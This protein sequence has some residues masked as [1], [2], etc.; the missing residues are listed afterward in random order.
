MQSRQVLPGST[1]REFVFSRKVDDDV[2]SPE[3]TPVD[4]L[5][6]S[7]T[8]AIHTV[9][10]EKTTRI[11]AESVFFKTLAANVTNGFYVTNLSTTT[12]KII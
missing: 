6:L 4:G 11:R 5:M 7:A 12:T 10:D 1:R 3:N 2:P 8:A 9:T